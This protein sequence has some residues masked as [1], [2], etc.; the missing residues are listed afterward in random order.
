MII[1]TVHGVLIY[2]RPFVS[3]L[4]ALPHS[5]STPPP[6][7][8]SSP[9]YRW[10]NGL[11]SWCKPSRGF[12]LRVRPDPPADGCITCSHHHSISRYCYPYE[13]RFPNSLAYVFKEQVKGIPKGE[14]NILILKQQIS[15]ISDKR[16]M[17]YFPSLWKHGVVWAFECMPPSKGEIQRGTP[18]SQA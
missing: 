15:T 10:A 16:H 5:I 6:I 8:G 18:S 11:E 12:C 1:M 2:A 3:T 7:I 13:S 17:K 14:G 4:H 9:A